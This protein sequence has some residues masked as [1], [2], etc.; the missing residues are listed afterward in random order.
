MTQPSQARQ[1][2]GRDSVRTYAWPPLP[3]HEFEVISVTS[4]LDAGVAK[5]W[6]TGWAAKV[7]A[8]A[9]VDDHAIVGAMLEKGDEDAALAHIKGARWR[10]TN[11]KA[12]RGTIVHAALEAYLKGQDPTP[13]TIEA[14]LEEARVNRSLWKSTA[15]MVAGVMEFLYDEEPEIYWSEST[16]YSRQHGYAG[17]ADLIARVRVGG[18]RK[19]AVLDV[20]TSPK[21]Y[22]ETAAQLCAYARADFVG[23]D[24][25]SEMPLVPLREV[26]GMMVGEPIEHGI[27][28]RPTS[29]GK[30]EAVTFSLTDDVFDF[31]LGALQVAKNKPAL[32]AA[33][34]PS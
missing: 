9:A 2:G 25:G 31:F 7:T 15:G 8:Q 14:A 10:N 26:D 22:D 17:T 34:R 30:Y 29:S 32:A 4:A 23:L 28:I 20:K 12:K 19:P 1:G 16:V 11:R 24:D 13:A 33:R 6:L 3:P 21:V 18:S 27:V 5:P